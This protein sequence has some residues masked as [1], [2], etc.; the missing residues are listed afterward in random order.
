MSAG[1]PYKRQYFPREKNI[2]IHSCLS[3]AF[4]VFFSPHSIRQHTSAY[5]SIV[6]HRGI[7][8]FRTHGQDGRNVRRKDLEKIVYPTRKK[9]RIHSCLY[10]LC[11]LL[12]PPLPPPKQT[13]PRTKR[14]HCTSN[15]QR[16][17]LR[18]AFS[19]SRSLSRSRSGMLSRSKL[20]PVVKVRGS[21]SINHSRQPVQKN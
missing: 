14:K 4:S 2:R 21:G 9:I 3:T 10:F 19:L 7:F 18:A 11:L 20:M 17:C 1:E 8:F 5:V 13:H 16:C 12:S 15:P 6:A